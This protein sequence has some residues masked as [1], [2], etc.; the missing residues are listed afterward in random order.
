MCRRGRSSRLD[1]YF[2]GAQG[3]KGEE[4]TVSSVA[5]LEAAVGRE[6]EGALERELERATSTAMTL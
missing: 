4:E 2:F 6:L 1:L 5:D 3:R